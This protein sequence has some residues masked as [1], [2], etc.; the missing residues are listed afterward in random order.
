MEG[1]HY[2]SPEDPFVAYEEENPKTDRADN[3]SLAVSHQ[4]EDGRDDLIHQEVPPEQPP[5]VVENHDYPINPEVGQENNNQL[6][7]Y[8]W[9]GPVDQE[10]VPAY[11]PSTG[12]NEEKMVNQDEPPGRIAPATYTDDFMPF[13]LEEMTALIPMAQ[14][15]LQQEIEKATNPEHP[16][17]TSH[18]PSEPHFFVDYGDRQIQEVFN[19]P[20]EDSSDD[21]IENI[22][23]DFNILLEDVVYKIRTR[24]DKVT[25]MRMKKLLVAVSSGNWPDRDQDLTSIS[26]SYLVERILQMYPKKSTLESCL[27]VIVR[28]L[29]KSEIY[30]HIVKL[31]LDRLQE[32]YHLQEWHQLLIA[33][34]QAE[35]DEGS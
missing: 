22:T 18:S 35:L 5:I 20:I 24:Y 26:F 13:A 15:N 21:F 12:V 11:S 28:N 25:R 2:L 14:T 6:S 17:F 19:Q 3:D 30:E 16:I 33:R 4:D 34:H 32:V 9:G 31:L 29:N 8:S 1:Q 10:L 27:R 23:L 7:V